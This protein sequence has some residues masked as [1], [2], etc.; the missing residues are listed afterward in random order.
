M[1]LLAS[2]KTYGAKI[3]FYSQI[4]GEAADEEVGM[5]SKTTIES[6]KGAERIIEAI[7]VRV[8]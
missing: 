3:T 2:N 4:P 1:E 8:N 7:E 6:V 5:A